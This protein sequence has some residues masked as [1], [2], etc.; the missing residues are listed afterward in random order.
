[1]SVVWLTSTS[2]IRLVVAFTPKSTASTPKTSV[3]SMESTIPARRHCRI[4]HRVCAVHTVRVPD[5]KEPHPEHLY[6]PA[7][8][9]RCDQLG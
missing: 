5:A 7:I 4:P 2:G 1:M 6:P 8:V 3:V 9:E